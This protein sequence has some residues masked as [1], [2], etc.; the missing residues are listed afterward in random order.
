MGS[1]APLV[2][3]NWR[4][5][6]DQPFATIPQLNRAPICIHR[7]NTEIMQMKCGSGPAPVA[8]LMSFISVF[9]F[10]TVHDLMHSHKQSSAHF[11]LCPSSE[12]NFL[13]LTTIH[14][15][16]RNFIK[17]KYEF[18]CLF[19]FPSSSSARKMFSVSF[20]IK[21]SKTKTHFLHLYLVYTFVFS[22]AECYC[23][24]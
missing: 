8:H 24:K 18:I 11:S 6:K 15:S 14:W 21:E 17:C 10:T 23:F 5:S 3:L 12:M 4:R 9:F 7:S 22:T 2:A 20:Q 16:D 13:S 1:A 19:R